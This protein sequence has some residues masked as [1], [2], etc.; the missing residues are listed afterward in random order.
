VLTRKTLGARQSLGDPVD[1]RRARRLPGLAGDQLREFGRAEAM[2]G[3]PGPSLVLPADPVDP[4]RF[5][6]AGGERD[7]LPPLP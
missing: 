2:L 7:P 3:R 4:V 6:H 1:G 5:C